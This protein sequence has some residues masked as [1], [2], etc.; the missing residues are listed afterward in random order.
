MKHKEKTLIGIY[1]YN[2]SEQEYTS[3]H[4]GSML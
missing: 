4:L 3:L 2:L 1:I